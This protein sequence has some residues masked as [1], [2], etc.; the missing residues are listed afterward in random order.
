MHALQ[1]RLEI[2]VHRELADP[3]DERQQ[4][5]GAPHRIGESPAQLHASVANSAQSVDERRDDA[6][7]GVVVFFRHPAGE[8]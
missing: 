4:P 5:G 1:H 8:Q 6:L 3:A 2:A 7:S